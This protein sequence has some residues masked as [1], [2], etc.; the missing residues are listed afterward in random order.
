M[1]VS[2]RGHAIRGFTLIELLV[3]LAISAL[4][5]GILG[6]VLGGVRQHKLASDSWWKSNTR[7]E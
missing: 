6:N 3:A 7:K 5:L 2:D 1:T 4:L